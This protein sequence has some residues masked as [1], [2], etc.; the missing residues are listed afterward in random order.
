MAL[1]AVLDRL[2]LRESAMVLEARD[3]R[4]LAA[5]PADGLIAECWDLQELAALYRGF[6]ERFEPVVSLIEEAREPQTAFVVQTLLIHA[7][8]RV[9]LHDPRFPA[10]L[11]PEQWPGHAAYRLCREIYLQLYVADQLLFGGAAG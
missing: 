7:F 8:R 1:T 2:G 4:A 3:L 9:V 6:L 11:L 10:E 5:M